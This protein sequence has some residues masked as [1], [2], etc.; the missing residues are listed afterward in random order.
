MG[1]RKPLIAILVSIGVGFGAI[2][3]GQASSPNQD[4]LST[5]SYSHGDDTTN[6]LVVSPYSLIDAQDNSSVINEGNGF[7]ISKPGI[8]PAF[9]VGVGRYFYIYLTPRDW[10]FISS[11]GWAAAGGA[12][13][14]LAGGGPLA[15][16][17]C[18][19]AGGAI[20][21]YLSDKTGPKGNQCAEVKIRLGTKP[22][23][24]KVINKPCSALK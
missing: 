7:Y 17:L 24:Y 15:G 14:T 9:H 8:S 19:A 4:Y 10:N 2:P 22:A 23:G 1:L 3:F 5:D 18:G 11:T 20:G 12:L 13:C 16:A 21:W 6:S